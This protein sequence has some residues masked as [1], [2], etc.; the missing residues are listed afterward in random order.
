MRL[1][2]FFSFVFFFWGERDG[3]CFGE[4]ENLFSGRCFF[5]LQHV[6]EPVAGV[7]VQQSF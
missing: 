4:E 1:L 6:A 7:L 5:P 3:V 2:G